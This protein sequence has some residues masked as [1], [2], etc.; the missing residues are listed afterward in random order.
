[1]GNQ[2]EEQIRHLFLDVKEP[3]TPIFPALTSQLPSLNLALYTL[4]ERRTDFQSG[5]LKVWKQLRELMQDIR[6]STIN[7]PKPL[8][9]TQACYTLQSL[10]HLVESQARQP[11]IRLSKTS[12]RNITDLKETFQAYARQSLTFQFGQY[13]NLQGLEAYVPEPPAEFLGF[14]RRADIIARDENGDYHEFLIHEID[15]IFLFLHETFYTFQKIFLANTQTLI[16][17]LKQLHKIQ[18]IHSLK[19]ELASLLH[20]L[21]NFPSVN[22]A[23]KDTAKAKIN[24]LVAKTKRDL[25]NLLPCLQEPASPHSQQV[26]HPRASPC[27]AHSHTNRARRQRQPRRHRPD[28]QAQTEQSHFSPSRQATPPNQVHYPAVGDETRHNL[29]HLQERFR[30]TVRFSNH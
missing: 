7:N 2:I 8:D 22:W 1:M 24:S 12:Q 16:Q 30:R 21:N 19:P 5:E 23:A 6:F 28:G 18:P 4:K 20:K 9:L 10:T 29:L 3:L 26:V 17:Y 13:L 11:T 27:P 15:D 25:H 14:I